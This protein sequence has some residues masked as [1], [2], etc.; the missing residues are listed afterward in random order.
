M[1][2]LDLYLMTNHDRFEFDE[3]GNAHLT[4]KAT[5][6]ALRVLKSINNSLL[7][8]KILYKIKQCRKGDF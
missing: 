1:T 5:P 7:I 4:S 3:S 6:E 2:K 8:K